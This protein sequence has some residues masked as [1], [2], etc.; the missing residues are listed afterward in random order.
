M[1]FGHDKGKTHASGK[2]LFA[3]RVIPYRGSWLDFE[4]DAKDILHVR[5]DRKRKLPA[6]VLLQ[7]LGYSQEKILDTFYNKVAYKL[8]KNGWVTGFSADRWKGVRPDF[9]LVAKNSKEENLVLSQQRADETLM[10]WDL[11]V[12]RDRVKQDSRTDQKRSV[13]DGDKL[14]SA[15]APSDRATTRIATI[16]N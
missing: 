9:D 3:A 16:P 5:I 8:D 7:A 10:V 4:F 12:L 1:S 13:C 11:S 6:T 15:R 2:L 14:H